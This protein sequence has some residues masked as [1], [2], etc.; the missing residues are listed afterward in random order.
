MA[1]IQYTFG[2]DYVFWPAGGAVIVELVEVERLPPVIYESSYPILFRFALP[3]VVMV[4][5]MF[6]FVF[7]AV[8]VSVSVMRLLFLLFGHRTFQFLYPGGR[9]HG[10]FEIKQSGVQKVFHRNIAIVA[11][12]NPG[13]RLQGTYHGAY[14][15]GLFGRD[16]G[17]FVEQHEVAEL[18]LSDHKVLYLFIVYVGG[19]KSLS[20]LEIG[21]HPQGVYDSDYTV[22]ARPRHL[23]LHRL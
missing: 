17:N 12:D 23:V 5:A 15:V 4:V 6:M 19:G 14:F 7:M 16:L 13:L 20:P 11:P 9:R 2:A 22:Q 3:V 1:E 10:L 21:K 18:Y 8:V